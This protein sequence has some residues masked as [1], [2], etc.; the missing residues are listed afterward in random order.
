MITARSTASIVVTR[1]NP[2]KP[3]VVERLE[4]DAATD[5]AVHAQDLGAASWD[6]DMYQWHM[7]AACPARGIKWLLGFHH[8]KRDAFI[9]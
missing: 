7:G 3:H 8:E 4:K 5:G 2:V 1:A 6:L 9:V